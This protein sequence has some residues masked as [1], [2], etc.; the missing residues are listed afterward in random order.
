MARHS[1]ENFSTGSN[2]IAVRTKDEA[3]GMHIAPISRLLAGVSR[4][5]SRYDADQVEN[6]AS[7]TIV[8]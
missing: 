7:R 3:S 5:T 6:C 8:L 1:Q 4:I 2:P